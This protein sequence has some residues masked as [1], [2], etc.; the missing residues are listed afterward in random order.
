MKKH[1]IIP[2]FISHRGCPHQCVFCNQKAITARDGDVSVEDA[3]N[4][5]EQWLT[6]L[7]GK[8]MELEISFFG[9]SFTGIPIEEQTAFL[10]LAKE[11]KDSGRVDKIHCSTRPDYISAEILDNLKKYGMDVIELG[12]QSFDQDVLDKSRRGHSVKDVEDACAL[13]RKYGFTLGI[14]LM[15][16]LPGDSYESCMYS[17]QKAIEM[18]PEIARLYPTV[19]IDRTPLADMYE[20][21]EYIPPSE[22]EI[23]RRTK[24][25]YKALTLAGIN[26]I[27]IGL[28]SNELIKGDTYH[29]AIGQVV[30]ASAA[31]DLIEEEIGSLIQSD[32]ELRCIEILA[33]ASLFD[34]A[35]GHGASNRKYFEEKY[36]SLRFRFRKDD[37]IESICVRKGE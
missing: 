30:K 22:E 35:V 11:Y 9:G 13:I 28:K 31:R 19:V 17:A 4:T 1:A 21:G 33:P 6:T 23:V 27:R 3:R 5:I 10:K 37:E 16:G 7:E 36:P 20:R 26:V 12:V 24:D 14:Q 8:G 15:I 18:K 2:I 25:M 34:F 29:P 32:P